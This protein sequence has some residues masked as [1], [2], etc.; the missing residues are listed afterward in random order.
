MKNM[1]LI[2]PLLFTLHFSFFILKMDTFFFDI[3]RYA[4]NDGPGIRI[5]IFFKGC[6]LSCIWCHNPEGISPYKEKIYTSKRCL[7]CKRCVEACPNHALQLAA[8]GIVT[9][10][11]SCAVCGECAEVCPSMSM[12]ISGRSY[13]VE[14]LMCEIERETLVMDQSKGGVTFSGGEPLMHPDVL[15]ELLGQCGKYGIHRAVDTTLFA[16]SNIVAT[17]MHETDLFLV[18][19][20]HMDPAKH[21]FFCGVSNERILSNIRLL[22]GNNRPFIIRIPL[23]EGVNADEENITET[24]RF[25]S[26][27]TWEPKQVNLLLYHNIGLSKHEKR[28]TIYNPD[29][30]LM[31]T[32]SIEVQQKCM[33]IFRKYGIEPTLS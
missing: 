33:Y 19:L 4:I 9:D 1:T 27:L 31:Q 3:K 8:E 15:M 23:I 16:K 21:Q 25:L 20:K 29:N 24:A 12:E 5:T 6:P 2:Q 7:G 10:R 30:A 11:E 17:I 22:A 14:E 28:G 13:S 26:D 32:P 18:D